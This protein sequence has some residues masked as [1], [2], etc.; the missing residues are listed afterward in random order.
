MTC[1]NIVSLPEGLKVAKAL[2]LDRGQFLAM[3]EGSTAQSDV[4]RVWEK[5]YAGLVKEHIDGFF[6]GLRP[7]IALAHDLDVP[8]PLTAL[9]QQLLREAFR[10]RGPTRGGGG[11]VR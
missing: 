7:A 4:S 11:E 1:A 10:E 6:E 8:I 3:L 9:S 2:G 5:R